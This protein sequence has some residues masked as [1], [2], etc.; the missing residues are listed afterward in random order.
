MPEEADLVQDEESVFDGLLKNHTES[1]WRGFTLQHH[2]AP[3]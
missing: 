3:R 1:S 2:A